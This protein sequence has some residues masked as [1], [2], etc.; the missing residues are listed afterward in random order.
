MA[1]TAVASPKIAGGR[2]GLLPA[3]LIAV[4]V[5]LGVFWVMRTLIS[6]DYKFEET[7]EEMV[8]IELAPDVSPPE[9]RDR[10][11]KPETVDEV[12]PPPP[13]P[14]IEKQAA[15]TPKES[16]AAISG[17]IPD[18]E[19]PDIS[20]DNFRFQVSDRDA[21]PIVAIPPQYPPNAASRG[22]EGD[23]LTIFDVSA[24][25]R[26]FNIRF[27]ACPSVFQS[28][29]R[30]AVEKFKFEPKIVDGQAVSRSG[31]E[32]EFKYRLDE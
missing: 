20:G 28:S 29:S 21:R 9:I 18:F 15:A 10:E 5:V 16:L 17:A 25:G 1:Q 32:Y 23:C 6:T 8:V 19:A 30:R 12:E 7:D 3:I 31:V 27:G 26:P 14:Q 24:D 13:P 4:P 11:I 22:T 2:F